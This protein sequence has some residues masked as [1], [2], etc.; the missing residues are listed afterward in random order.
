MMTPFAA[1][2]GTLPLLEPETTTKARRCRK[3]R[4]PP[5]S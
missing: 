2:T 5:G 1:K 4:C 3:R